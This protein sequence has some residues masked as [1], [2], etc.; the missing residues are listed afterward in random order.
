MC[1]WIPATN[2]GVQVLVLAFLVWYAFET[3]RLRKASQEQIEALQKPCITV[4]TTA[5]SPEDTI[6]RVNDVVGGMVLHQI[7]GC[8]GLWNIGAGSA[9]SISYKFSC[10]RHRR[11]EGAHISE[12]DGYLPYI[13][14]GAQ[15]AMQVPIETLRSQEYELVASYESLSGRRYQTKININNLVVAAVQF[16]LVGD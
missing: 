11:Q 14:A 13:T 10:I 8:V 16:R 7:E 5:R 6:L 4:V 12:P 3:Y 9:F 15:F 2:L 1:H